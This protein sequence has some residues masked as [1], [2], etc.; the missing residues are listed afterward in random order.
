MLLSCQGVP[1]YVFEEKLRKAKNNLNLTNMVKKL[2]KKSSEIVENKEM[3][4]EKR[5]KVIREMGMFFG[6]SK[7]FSMVF[8][9]ALVRSAEI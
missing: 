1:D 3:T 5:K 9:V 7:I 4:D 2:N 6:P 8:K